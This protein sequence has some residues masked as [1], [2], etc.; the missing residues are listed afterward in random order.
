MIQRP[1]H[2]IPVA[3]GFLSW[4][5]EVASVAVRLGSGS[6][7]C[8]SSAWGHPGHCPAHFSPR[9]KWAAVCQGTERNK[10]LSLSMCTYSF[11]QLLLGS[12]LFSFHLGLKGT[13]KTCNYS[14]LE[15][16]PCTSP[17]LLPWQP[18]QWAHWMGRSDTPAATRHLWSACRC[19]T[20]SACRRKR[21]SL[22]W[23]FLSREAQR[24]HRVN[25]ADGSC[26]SSFPPAW[27]E[28]GLSTSHIPSRPQG[29][30]RCKPFQCFFA[31]FPGNYSSPQFW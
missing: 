1:K 9:P 21:W 28:E 3:Q 19:L 10:K 27:C 31:P 7:G 8:H 17:T 20:A 6:E 24:E 14:H 15:K 2:S 30:D 25:G 22:W 16:Q 18:P 29:R 12:I 23:A 26:Y 4:S 13:T 11:T 5:A